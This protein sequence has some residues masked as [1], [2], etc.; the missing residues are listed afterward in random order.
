VDAGEP[1]AQPGDHLVGSL[2]HA[3]GLAD[4]QHA[5]QN[6]IQGAGVKGDHLGL[7]A[8]DVQGLVDV[9]G[10]DRADRAQV[11]GQHQLGAQVVDGLG[12]EP[13]ERLAAAD[14]GADQPVDLRRLGGR[15]QR[16]V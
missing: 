13:V 7:A 1:L 10:G 3:G 11:L 4:L 5:V 9:A 6:L 16:R 12:V 2:L 14:A 15:R 8:Q